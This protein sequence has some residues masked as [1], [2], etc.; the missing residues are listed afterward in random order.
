MPVGVHIVGS[1]PMSSS[2]EVFR[3]LAG[4][5]GDRVKRLPDGETGERA[6]F[7]GWQVATFER[8]PDFEPATGRRLLEVVKP[9]RLKADVDPAS[10]SF[11][12]LGFA[13]A[14]ADSYEIFR[15]LRTE[16]VIRPGQRFLVSLPTPVNCLGMVLAQEHIADVEPAY[17][18]ALLAEVDRI[19]HAVPAADLAL[20]WDT[21]WEV[22]AWD[23]SLPGFL[24]QPW[25]PGPQEGILERLVRLGARIPEGVE[26]GYHL[27]HGDYEHTGNLMLGLHRQARNRFV[28]KAAGRV[29]RELSIRI[30]GPP[31]DMSSVV[32]M[33]NGLFERTTRRIDF[34][35]LPVPRAAGER[36]FQPLA[37]LRV[38]AGVEV[39]L[40][41]VHHTDGAAGSR[42]RI[43]EAGRRLKDFGVSTECGWGRRDP[44]TIDE[45]MAIHREVSQPLPT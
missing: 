34:L 6:L 32:A 31:K 23:G 44:A 25:F 22:R 7:A 2:E 12:E 17:E 11:A 35:H 20:Q 40:G 14:A 3:A 28:R 29:L 16:G 5:L 10:V 41:L 9:Q 39:Y 45:L 13:A 42:R 24:V 37:D 43:G 36:Y 1:L 4:G 38:P 15:R 26:L 18:R 21:P 33:A 19:V 8:H 27:C 30:A